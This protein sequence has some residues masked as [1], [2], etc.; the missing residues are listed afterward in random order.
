MQTDGG[1]TSKVTLIPRPNFV[2]QGITITDTLTDKITL[3]Y[4]VSQGSALGPLFALYTTQLSAVIPS[5]D[6]NHHLYVDD[7]QIYMSLSSSAR[8]ISIQGHENVNNEVKNVKIGFSTKT[9]RKRRVVRCFDI[10]LTE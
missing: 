1:R 2:G 10:I 9:Y 5:F 6:I 3:S 7:I 4:R 8:A